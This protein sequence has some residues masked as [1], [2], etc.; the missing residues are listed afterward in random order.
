MIIF[1]YIARLKKIWKSSEKKIPSSISNEHFK[2]IFSSCLILH[3]QIK[4]LQWKLHI[5]IL[6]FSV[7]GLVNRQWEMN[8]GLMLRIPQWTLPQIFHTISM[9]R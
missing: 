6:L 7:D 3:S 2:A 1:K 8:A 9:R 4:S 5:K